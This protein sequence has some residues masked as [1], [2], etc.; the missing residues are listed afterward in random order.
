MGYR[1][2]ISAL[3]DHGGKRQLMV[4]GGRLM[5][6]NDMS[7]RGLSRIKFFKCQNKLEERLRQ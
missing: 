5:A 1:I 2:L 3:P 7:W 6:E 4:P